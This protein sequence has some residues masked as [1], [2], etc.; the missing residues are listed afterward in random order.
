MESGEI[1][2]LALASAAFFHYLGSMAVAHRTN[3]RNAIGA[4]SAF[5]L[6]RSRA[7]LPTLLLI[8][9]AGLNCRAWIWCGDVRLPLRARRSWRTL[10]RANG[11]VADRLGEP[12]SDVPK[13]VWNDTFPMLAGAVRVGSTAPNS[14]VAMFPGVGAPAS[15][16]LDLASAWHAQLPNTQFILFEADPFSGDRAISAVCHLVPAYFDSSKG[17]SKPATN[18]YSQDKYFNS[19]EVRSN[20]FGD[21]LLW[22]CNDVSNALGKILA[23]LGLADSNL[24]L[25]GFSQGA[26]VAAYTGFMRGVAGTIVMGGP[27]VVQLQLLPPLAKTKTQICVVSG[28]SD[29]LAPHEPLIKAFEPYG[30]NV[31]IIEGLE[32]KITADHVK[33]GGE[34]ILKVLTMRDADV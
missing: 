17:H 23:E 30:K 8:V 4:N 12:W 20:F 9:L 13:P 7:C 21:V 29:G 1:F 18:G 15:S 11:K 16:L 22:C 10:F 31:Y 24:V 34:F 33:F 2:P 26:S 27:G 6:T 25:A 28:D 32:H 19:S 5:S 14:V 3:K